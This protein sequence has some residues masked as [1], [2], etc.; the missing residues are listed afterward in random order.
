MYE[1]FYG[2]KEKP[3]SLTPD[4]RFLF[5][6]RAHQ[7]ALDHLTYGLKRKEGFICITGDVGTGKTTICRALLD[8]IDSQAKTALLL[9]PLLSEEELLKAVLEDF[10]LKTKSTSKK[11]LI[12]ELNEF[13]LEQLSSGGTT[14]LIIDEAQNL[15]FP[16]MEQV[17]L[18]SNLETDKE[19]LL[20]IIIVGQEE[21]RNKLKLPQLRQL[22]QRI[23]VRYH[24]TPLAKDEIPRYIQHRLVVAG[25]N[26]LVTLSNSALNLVAEYS[27]G[28]PRLINLLCDRSL[29]AGYT[30]STNY[31]SGE[32]VLQAAQSLQMEGEA[33]SELSFWKRL[34]SRLNV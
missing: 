26:G 3:F 24:L 33:V 25:S 28:I 13:L 14:I 7:A 29:L 6:S 30:M 15:S 18:L 16:A 27:K 20:Q 19:K 22:N 34:K 12:D 23:S 17:R 4:P 8:S 9:N 32:M 5:L 11:K 10:G 21:L 2:L 1:E 31:I